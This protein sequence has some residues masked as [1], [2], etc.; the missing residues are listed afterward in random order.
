MAQVGQWPGVVVHTLHAFASVGGGGGGRQWAGSSYAPHAFASARG[1]SVAGRRWGGRGSRQRAGSSYTRHAFA[2][3]R[4]VGVSGWPRAGSSSS[5]HST[6]VCERG[7]AEAVGGGRG[8]RIHP[9][10][11]ASV[12]GVGVAGVAGAVA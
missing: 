7:V 2:S 4:G 9:P 3:A 10:A 5:T 11:F 8:R 6:R 12:R 1:V